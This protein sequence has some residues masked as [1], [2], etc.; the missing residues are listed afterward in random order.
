MIPGLS[1]GS[2]NVYG[3]VAASWA[4]SWSGAATGA[5]TAPTPGSILTPSQKAQQKLKA[6]ALASRASAPQHPNI[7]KADED[8]DEYSPES[9]IDEGEAEDTNTTPPIDDDIY[10]PELP[11]RA[12]E[13]HSYPVDNG[14]EDDMYDP[15][16]YA[17][18]ENISADVSPRSFDTDGRVS[19]FDPASSSNPIPTSVGASDS[20]NLV[21]Q[22]SAAQDD[23]ISLIDA[24]KKAQAAILRLWPLEVRYQQ[25]IEEGIEEN[26]IKQLFCDLGLDRSAGCLQTSKQK[27]PIAKSTTSQQDSPSVVDGM[28]GPSST[29]ASQTAPPSITS[30]TTSK[31][32]PTQAVE[33]ATKASNNLEERKDRIAR[34]LAMNKAGQSQAVAPLATAPSQSL[35][36]DVSHS[37]HKQ[38]ASLPPKPPTINQT[39]SSSDEALQKQKMEALAT[40]RSKRISTTSKADDPSP[41]STVAEPTPV[42]DTS[43]PK[44]ASTLASITLPRNAPTGPRAFISA[45]QQTSIPNRTRLTAPN[46]TM[47]ST[48]LQPV[49]QPTPQQMPLV[50]DVSA[51]EDEEDSHLAQ[52]NRLYELPSTSNSSKVLSLNGTP[53]NGSIK[54]GKQVAELDRDIDQ[55][56][57]KIAE[58]EARKST[59]SSGTPI[60]QQQQQQ[61]QA[62]PSLS[63]PSFTTR[64]P[65]TIP[66]VGLSKIKKPQP[67]SKKAKKKTPARKRSAKKLPVVEAMLAKKIARLQSVNLEAMKLLKE[68]EDAQREKLRLEQ[69]T[70]EEADDSDSAEENDGGTP[71]MAVPEPPAIPI[72]GKRNDLSSAQ[73]SPASVCRQ[74][75]SQN[76]LPPKPP[77]PSVTIKSTAPL[78]NTA[79]PTSQQT[80]TIVDSISPEDK[81]SDE[82]LENDDSTDSPSSKRARILTKPS[83]KFVNTSPTPL[84]DA[85]DDLPMDESNSDVSDTSSS[86]ESDQSDDE[87]EEEKGKSDTETD[88]SHVVDK[89][90]TSQRANLKKG[91]SP[92]HVPIWKQK[93]QQ[94]QQEQAITQSQPSTAT[95]DNDSDQEFNGDALPTVTSRPKFAADISDVFDTVN[96][97]PYPD[98]FVP[99]ESI[100]KG[101]AYYCFHPSFDGDVATTLRS[102]TYSNNIDPNWAFCTD[103]LDDGGCSKGADC[104]WQHLSN[105]SIGEDKILVALGNSNGL[106]HADRRRFI[107][108]LRQVLIDIKVRDVKDFDL[109]SKTILDYRRNFLG[110]ASKIRFM[111]VDI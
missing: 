53:V 93:M 35:S 97:P 1:S 26:V 86:E 21:N 50:I 89:T 70:K 82:G 30:A 17:P 48:V 7:Y 95:T 54:G 66:Q 72:L 49:S 80:E 92:P 110:D 4:A 11:T 102:L 87:K 32:S 6:A 43:T 9:H 63:L 5:A 74:S 56:K 51:D 98:A 69:E 18:E 94:K 42:A 14:N 37:V 23:E 79:L 13:D 76:G 84:T 78:V 108:G 59:S 25:Y 20:D 111:D 29:A 81:S 24:R 41:V 52:N 77:T 62:L 73:A 60:S 34:H 105:I 27:S 33:T 104:E 68:I 64:P 107:D 45:T 39:A 19:D 15:D 55:L 8:D 101:N 65:A 85:E 46:A 16:A 75:R 10:E 28:S 44:P 88:P 96:N 103:D 57:R 12:D 58:M 36:Q 67:A 91:S 61:K 47:P 3:N 83:P 22:P 109:I 99:Y 100:Y 2:G 90:L 71:K 31:A 40:M 38:I 106:C